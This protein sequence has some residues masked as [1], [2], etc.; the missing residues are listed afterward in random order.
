[1]GAYKWTCVSNS[2]RTHPPKDDQWGPA[3]QEYTDA[4]QTSV[5]LSAQ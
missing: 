2:P 3:T 4:F 1:M 5:S